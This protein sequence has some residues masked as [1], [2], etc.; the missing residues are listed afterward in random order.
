MHFGIC[1][2]RSNRRAMLSTGLRS[3]TLFGYAKSCHSLDN[4]QLRCDKSEMWEVW[5]CQWDVGGWKCR[6]DITTVSRDL[7]VLHMHCLQLWFMRACMIHPFHLAFQFL[8][9]KDKSCESVLIRANF[10][11]LP[12]LGTLSRPWEHRIQMAASGLWCIFAHLL[13]GQCSGPCIHPRLLQTYIKHPPDIGH[14]HHHKCLCQI[15]FL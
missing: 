15:V 3:A 13:Y 12:H 4:I 6:W 10:Y 1:A 2:D 9:Q 8:Q 14:H 11:I 5:C 7:E